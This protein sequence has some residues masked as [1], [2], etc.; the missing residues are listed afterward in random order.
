M[1]RYVGQ[2]L[3]LYDV[4]YTGTSTLRVLVLA[5]DAGVPRRG[6]LGTV[7]ITLSNSCLLDA[8]LRPIGHAVS[9]GQDT[10]ELTLRVPGYF[11]YDYG[12]GTA[13]CSMRP[14]TGLC[15]SKEELFD[16]VRS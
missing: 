6:A 13:T 2:L 16:T 15:T 14:G 8:L 10:G 5:L 9:M 1:S 11:I 7:N 3:R 12:E 4:V